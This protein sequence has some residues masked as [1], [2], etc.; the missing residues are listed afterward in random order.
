MPDSRPDQLMK[1]NR[2]GERRRHKRYRVREGALAFLGSIPGKII[3][4]SR[5]GVS[6]NY[7]VFEKGPEQVLKL[8]IFFPE[9]DF[10]LPGIPACVVSEIDSPAKLPFSAVQTKRIG[11]RFDGL[12]EKQE[13]ALERYLLQNA[14][15]E[16]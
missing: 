3:D 1:K 4:I 13:A 6:V 2:G 14:I 8:D 9:E 15:A 11:V 7:V 16:V 5:G 10:F 12:S